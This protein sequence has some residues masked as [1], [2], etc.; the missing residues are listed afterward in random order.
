[1]DGL[2]KIYYNSFTWRGES[3]REVNSQKQKDC[4]QQGSNLKLEDLFVWSATLFGDCHVFTH[5]LSSS[6]AFRHETKT[7]NLALQEKDDYIL[8]GYI[9]YILSRHFSSV[10]SE[11]NTK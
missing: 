1:M 2:H 6:A 5:T 4:V 3:E 7:I 8:E 10:I 11:Q 9:I